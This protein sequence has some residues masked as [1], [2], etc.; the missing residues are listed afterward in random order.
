MSVVDHG[1]HA[2]IHHRA[3]ELR[4][5]WT[6][7]PSVGMQCLA[8]SRLE[9]CPPDAP[10]AA[11]A[12]HLGP[13][14]GSVCNSG[15]EKDVGVVKCES[16]C[17][18]GAPGV[19]HSHCSWCKCRACEV[20]RPKPPPDTNGAHGRGPVDQKSQAILAARDRDERER[21]HER[22]RQREAH[23]APGASGIRS[24]TGGASSSARSTFKGPPATVTLELP[25][26]SA[27]PSEP[28]DVDPGLPTFFT[29]GRELRVRWSGESADDDGEAIEMRGINW[30]GFE[31]KGAI[32]DGLWEHSMA[33]YCSMLVENGVNALRVPLAV[34][35]V[36]SDPKPT[37]SAWRDPVA[38][39][40]ASSLAALDLLVST[41]A[42]AGVLVLL[43][44]HRLVGE[45]WPDPRGLWYSPLVDEEHVHAA[46]RLVAHRYCAS[47]NVIGADLFKYARSQDL[48]PT[49]ESCYCVSERPAFEFSCEQRA[50]G[51][52]VGAWAGCRLRLG[53]G[54]REARSQRA[55]HVPAVGGVR[56]GR[57]CAGA[58]EPVL[59]GGEH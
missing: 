20:C 24:N 33:Q 53:G 57:R 36:L 8:G 45:I 22:E 34:D 41:A 2:C 26:A 42:Q 46:W 7:V 1:M 18:V 59:L 28:P 17:K 27:T 23:R 13:A 47:W 50:M 25:P 56:R 12:A 6:D 11:K 58:P 9:D 39:K 16:W 4:C 30:F 37:T 52:R 10:A 5:A 54:R 48:E 14:I 40:L 35:N 43:D 51:R 15:I 32:V 49:P 3:N 31:G 38:S 55:V 21:E 44:M 29:R 19:V